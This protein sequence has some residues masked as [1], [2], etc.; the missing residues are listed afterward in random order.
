MCYVEV[1]VSIRRTPA[2]WNPETIFSHNN[3]T[4][5]TVIRVGPHAASEILSDTKALFH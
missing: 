5:M 4:R 1:I 2:E 3:L